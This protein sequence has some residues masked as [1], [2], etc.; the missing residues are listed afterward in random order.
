M[1]PASFQQGCKMVGLLAC[2]RV[3]YMWM[4]RFQ[5]DYPEQTPFLYG[6]VG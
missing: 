1:P 3:G 4:L 6:K 2:R 5:L